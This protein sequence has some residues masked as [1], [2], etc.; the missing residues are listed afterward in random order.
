MIRVVVCVAA[1]GLVVVANV[2][3]LALLRL[4]GVARVGRGRKG[5][6][7]S[8]PDTGPLVASLGREAQACDDAIDRL[9]ALAD[10]GAD[11]GVASEIYDLTARLRVAVELVRCLRR[12]AE[13]RTVAD[14]HRAFGA[15]GDWGYSTPL[16][17]ALARL[18]RGEGGDST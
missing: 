12:L 15:P 8:A 3:V 5:A 4:R 13:G 10:D 17:D 14:L 9:R 7:V 16:G 1:V 2:A 11:D 18:Y 6:I